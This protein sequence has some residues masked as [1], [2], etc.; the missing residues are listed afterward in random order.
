MQY[1][2]LINSWSLN[3]SNTVWNYG[4]E[5]PCNLEGQYVHL[6]AYLDHLSTSYE[7]GVCSYGIMGTKYVR[8]EPLPTSVEV[9]QGETTSVLIPHIYSEIEIGTEMAIDL[10]CAN[11]TQLAFV[12]LTNKSGA[13]EVYIDVAGVDVGD[14]E[15]VL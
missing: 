9:S 13:T 6:V 5:V 8:A 10:R 3:G 11:G 12:T 1:G 4:K 2:D 7:V 15:L 14:Y